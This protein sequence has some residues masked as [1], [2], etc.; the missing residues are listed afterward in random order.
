M[1]RKVDPIKQPHTF[2]FDAAFPA[3]N[4]GFTPDGRLE[5]AY[6]EM[7]S[8]AHECDRL[9][10]QLL[11]DAAYMAKRFNEMARD[12]NQGMTVSDPTGYSTV[13]DIPVNLVRLDM[14]RAQL[15]SLIEAYEGE[16]SQVRVKAFRENLKKA[17]VT[18]AHP[19]AV[20]KGTP[21]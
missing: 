15:V 18:A 10:N 12:L 9:H 6:Y 14:R 21:A 17:F 19:D 5:R 2:A 20:V 1:A 13:R 3:P 11:A 4:D 8:C 7:M 16:A